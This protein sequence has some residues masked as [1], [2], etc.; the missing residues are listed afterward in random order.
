LPCLA[1]PS[2]PFPSLPFPSL[3]FPSLPFPSL[4]VGRKPSG[5]TQVGPARRM[6]LEGIVC[7]LDMRQR[8]SWRLGGREVC[9]HSGH[10]TG[11]TP[12]PWC[13]YILGVCIYLVPVDDSGHFCSPS[14][15]VNQ[16]A[17]FHCRLPDPAWLFLRIAVRLLWGGKKQLRQHTDL[18]F[19]SLR[20][21]L[22]G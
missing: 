6:A 1:L 17:P 10:W 3:P 13:A 19:W 5:T 16:P 18:G 21:L 14:T 7:L 4:P 8:L 11:H 12:A 9:V 15:R 20:L 22:V 2:L